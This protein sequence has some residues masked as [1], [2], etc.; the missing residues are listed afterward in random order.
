MRTSMLLLIAL[1]LTMSAAAATSVDGI[2]TVV[3]L[4]GDS[5]VSV[6][7][8]NE[9]LTAT[10]LTASLAAFTKDNENDGK[11]LNQSREVLKLGST[12]GYDRTAQYQDQLFFTPEEFAQLMETSTRLEFI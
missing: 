4:G 8:V 1:T 9:D 5:N 6:G 11:P 7:D 2:D 12:V 3:K 10:P